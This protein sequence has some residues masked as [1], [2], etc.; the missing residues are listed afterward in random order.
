M[1]VASGPQ[2]ISVV[3]GSGFSRFVY[4]A[5]PV[6]VGRSLGPLARADLAEYVRYVPHHGVAAQEKLVGD[7]L[8]RVTG[9]NKTQDLYLAL[10]QSVGIRG[11]GGCPRRFSV[12][13]LPAALFP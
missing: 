12:V 8:V 9:G 13:E 5:V 1:R 11:R 3:R 7:L 10:A 2:Q 4:Q 6:G